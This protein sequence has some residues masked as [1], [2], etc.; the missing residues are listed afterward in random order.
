LLILLLGAHMSGVLWGRL[1]FSLLITIL[2][3]RLPDWSEGS[4]IIRYGMNRSA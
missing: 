3:S 2:L 1:I 4:A